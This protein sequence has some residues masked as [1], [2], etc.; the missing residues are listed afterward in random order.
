[1]TGRSVAAYP[2]RKRSPDGFGRVLVLERAE[3]D[4]GWSMTAWPLL[5]IT[6]L[7]GFRVALGRV[8]VP[9][10]AW[11]QRRAAA[12]VKLLALAPGHY[13]HREQI[14]DTLWPELEVDSAANNLRV[15]LYHARRQLADAAGD[16]A[17]V[18]LTR[19]GDGL[20]LGPRDQLRIDLD[21]FEMAVACVW[22]GE[23][24]AQADE[25]LRLYRG[26]LLPEDP[27]EDWIADRRTVI[28]T[29][30]RTLLARQAEWYEGQGRLDQ[31]IVVRQRQVAA[32]QLDES[33]HVHLIRLQALAGQTG[34]AL[35]QYDQLVALLEREL[36]AEPE[37]ETQ[38]LGA[39]IREGRF[40]A[41]KPAPAARPSV[42]P[43]VPAPLR[44][45][46]RLPDPLDE[47]VG[48]DRE[49]AEL[50]QLLRARRLLT[51]TGPGGVGK[52]RL[53]VAAARAVAS[54]RDGAAFV[55]LAPLV[56]PDLVLPEIARTLGVSEIGGES[57]LDTVI[58]A[59]GGTRLLV[60]VDNVEH[61]VT[62]APV[63]AEL[64]SACPGLCFLLTSRSRLRL[65]GEQEYPIVPLDL[66]VRPNDADDHAVT[67]HAVSRAPSVVLFDRRARLARPNFGLT[68][69]NAGAVAEI[70]HRLDGLPLA[71]EMAAARV[72]LLPPS[73][74]V[75]R[76]ERPLAV[77]GTGS[78][79]APARQRTLRAT[80]AWSYELLTSTERAL[81]VDLA[82]FAGGASLDAV[83]AVVA[84]TADTAVATVLEV[85]AALVDHSLLNQTEDSLGRGR[86]GMLATIQDYAR[87]QLDAR[88]DAGEI[89]HRHA[90]H[91]LALAESAAPELTGPE[92]GLWLDR[93]DIEHDN[94]RA[95]LR[96]FDTPEGAPTMLRLVASLWRFWWIRGY[97]TEGRRW[98][99]HALAA[100]PAATGPTAAT[101][102]DGAGVL[103]EAQGDLATATLRHEAALVIW[104]ALGDRH[105][106]L[107]SLLDL[108]LV[109]DERGE[110]ARAIQILEDALA[111]AREIADRAGIASCLANLGFAALEQGDHRT[112]DSRLRESLQLFRDLGDRRN[113]GAVLDSLGV[114]AFRDGDYQRAS[115]FHAEALTLL[116]E[117]RDQQGT[118]DTLSNYGHTVQRMGDLALA[119]RYYAEALALYRQL[120]DQS[121]VAF[122]LTHLGRL[123]S[124]ADDPRRSDALLREAFALAWRLGEKIIISEAMEGL[125][126]VALDRG[127]PAQSARLLGAAGA[128][129][130]AIA[131]PLPEVHVPE[132]Q[133]CLTRARALLGDDAF[134]A[135]L[136]EGRALLPEQALLA[137]AGGE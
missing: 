8:I 53:A 15:A 4:A 125:A 38:E 104:Q 92:Q 58:G 20:R 87:E 22:R 62:A 88:G 82:V 41:T 10:R 72:R 33:A 48:R 84:G 16:A 31:A 105:G 100:N 49:L 54:S 5:E 131:V 94:L 12:V 124:H 121:G 43:A 136:K 111:I 47:L 18:F 118:A 26:E 115:V 17:N 46:R 110:P 30:Y 91:F 108:G 71:I 14:L 69:A 51:L 70:C 75:R 127:E 67:V 76:L 101:A 90:A 81:F 117:L 106:Q 122:A 129:R 78:R 119:E 128:L 50:Q 73:E 132:H 52:T 85:T 2:A 19:D 123:A 44:I 6:L 25:A 133:R 97:L 86:L 112:A 134:A 83:E 59:V 107:R 35:A 103:A 13:L 61:V 60:L 120:G 109:A 34:R 57:L 130:E 99:E 95:A 80:I 1:M 55:D 89:R 96:N 37:R 93:L 135:A 29:S 63:L 137:L 114:L 102:L 98:I 74:L 40:P 126:T 113:L 27:Y 45:A 11:R 9:D 32:E 64:L 116:R 68:T 23:D 42:A 3:R 28:Q 7:G 77:L 36:A 39:A 66:P 56:D 21:R 79:D 65:Q 24:F